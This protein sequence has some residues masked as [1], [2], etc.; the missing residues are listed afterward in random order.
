[1][2]LSTTKIA[3]E[4]SILASETGGNQESGSSF[5]LIISIVAI[6]ISTATLI[7]SRSESQKKYL[8]DQR[9]FEKSRKGVIEVEEI[10][11]LS[12]SDDAP[13]SLVIRNTGDKYI[14]VVGFY[15][16]GYFVQIGTSNPGGQLLEN[17]LKLPPGGTEVLQLFPNKIVSLLR[18][19]PL[20]HGATVW[21]VCGKPT[22][23]SSFSLPDR[24]VETI[25]E[26]RE[27]F[28]QKNPD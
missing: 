22:E 17:K 18:D 11:N 6:I 15:L 1:M 26:H 20:K 19:N 23:G 12:L 27:Y 13:P 2:E 16:S 14:E 25:N 24:I 4:F 9:N 3:A 8:Q 21:L 5:G 7:S 10:S 28:Y